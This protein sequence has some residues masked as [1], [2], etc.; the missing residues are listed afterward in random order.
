MNVNPYELGPFVPLFDWLRDVPDVTAKDAY[1]YGLLARYR[2]RGPDGEC[3]PSIHTLA[4]VLRTDDRDVRRR[5]RKLEH[6]GLLMATS[7]PGQPNLYTFLLCDSLM[8]PGRSAP[9]IESPGVQPP[10]SRDQPGVPSSR[11]P[12]S[13]GPANK[14]REQ[15]TVIAAMRKRAAT[16]VPGAADAVFE[17][18]LR[19]MGKDPSRTKLN[20]KRLEKLRARR[21]DGYSDEQLLLAIDGCKLSAWHM[22]ENEKSELYNDLATIFRDGTT[23]EK[24]ADRAMDASPGATSAVPLRGDLQRQ[25]IDAQECGDAAAQRAI[26][27]QIDNQRTGAPVL[28]LISGGVK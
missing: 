6:A 9:G 15:D 22:G 23:V 16:R 1:L 27:A 25:L 28:N 18:W 20:G 4:A 11:H 10:A 13:A 26:R 19:V 17:H 2:G 7:R 24:H 21:R 12:G 3:R 8:S 14:I 5:L